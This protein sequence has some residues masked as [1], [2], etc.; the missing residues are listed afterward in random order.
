[1]LYDVTQ[2]SG[3]TSSSNSGTS[4]KDKILG[5]DDFLKMLVAQ[6]HYQDP[7]NPMESTDFSAQLAQFS[8]VEQLENIS[9]NLE[10]FID[11]NYLLT[12]SINNTLAANIIGKNVKAN[13]NAVYFNGID[14]VQIPFHLAGDAKNVKMEIY[15]ENGNLVRTIE[16]S[17]LHEGE[18]S[19]E[20]DGKDENGIR[21]NQGKYTVKISALDA[22]GA[23]VNAQTYMTGEITGIKYTDSGAVL[24]I[25]N[26]EVNFGDVIE[27]YG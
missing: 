4:I 22:E 8:S 14:N 26:L 13:G 1:M 6:L 19:L 20:W 7:M 24:L 18:N 17:D 3:F 2:T 12:T 23:T 16:A 27:I 15:D 21:V 9:N 11:S 5:K 25:G 10:S